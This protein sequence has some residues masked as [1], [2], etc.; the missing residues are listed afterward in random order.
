MLGTC[1]HKFLLRIIVLVT[2]I[3]I[4]MSALY[5]LWY[6]RNADPMKLFRNLIVPSVLLID[7]GHFQYNT[8]S[9]GLFLWACFF[10][11]RNRYLLAALFYC[12]SLNY[13]QMSL[14]YSLPIFF[15]ILKHCFDQKTIAAKFFKLLSVGGLVLVTFAILWFPYLKNAESALQ[16]VRRIFPLE[17]GIYEDKVANFWYC[18]SV[19]IKIKNL[20][21]SSWLTI[22]RF[23]F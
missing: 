18:I 8:V 15:Y 2:D 5:Y 7:Y 4:F 9:L 1:F 14:Y 21:P 3:L 16:V 17:R 11:E 20:I 12:L 6:Q 19:V 10:F 22:L 13:K 23:V